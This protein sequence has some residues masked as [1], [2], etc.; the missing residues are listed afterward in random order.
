MKLSVL[1]MVAALSVGGGLFA[2]Q[3]QA[4]AADS[5]KATTS[6]VV[7]D[8]TGDEISLTYRTV[9]YSQV[10]V[11]RMK[12]SA[13]GRKMWAQFMP[14]KLQASLQ[15][16][17]DLV[18]KAKNE[19]TLPAGKYSLSFGMNDALGWEMYLFT[20]DNKRAAK[21]ALDIKES[22]ISFDYLTLNLM[23]AGEHDYKLAV[24]YGKN[25]AVIPFSVKAADAKPS[26][27]Q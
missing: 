17:T 4:P 12:E 15:L 20:A 23:T 5:H 3:Q 21:I 25:A 1:A 13:E 19:Y 27:G 2:L 26:D 6:V 7:N 10:Q 11:D 14:Q 8:A 16:D 9:K 18:Y 22:M 24:G